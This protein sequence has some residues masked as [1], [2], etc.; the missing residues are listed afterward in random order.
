MSVR[1]HIVFVG[2]YGIQN[3]GDD[4]PLLVMT[5]GLRRR[6]PGVDFDFSVFG[7]HPDPMMEAASGARFQPNLEYESRA[8]AAGKWF[9]GFNFGDD[10]RELD[11][12]DAAIRDADLVVAGAGNVMI[13]VA[14]DL[15]R[16]PIPL[17]ASYAFMADLHRTPFML[18]G[19][20]A[21]P[22]A[23]QKAREVSAWI[24]RR[25]A[26]AT[27]RD[28]ASA[29]VLHEVDE[30]LELEVHPDP[31][32]GLMPASDA[33]FE[34]A[35]AI[36]GLARETVRPRLAVAWRDLDFLGF[37][38]RVLTD[39]LR[40]LASDYDLLFVPQ[41]TGVDCD[42][43]EVVRPIVRQLERELA[44]TGADRRID[45]LSQRHPPDVLM[46]FYE[47]ARVTIAARLH[48]ALFSARSGVPVAGIAYL[49]K[50]R[51]FLEAVG[52]ERSCVDLDDATPETIVAATRSA[53]AVD[54]EAL[55]QRADRLAEGV[56][57][58]LAHASTLLG[59]EARARTDSEPHRRDLDRARSTTRFLTP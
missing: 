46:R 51:S 19:I 26:V 18:Y 49:P 38:D 44:A 28:E 35:L 8:S 37:D 42:D 34:R 6:H 12:I 59:L 56:S 43:R 57:S 4:A 45:S 22:L 16:G 5:E 15:F 21:G 9:R 36:E 39:A 53:R 2:A 27:V 14:F 1:R 13:D 48:G 32:L 29:R 11:S 31:V 47:T 40:S 24:A 30:S 41:S 3:A 50:V 25:S 17:C 23:S 58:Y 54:G 10:R 7:R 55:R 20:T 52:L 33:A